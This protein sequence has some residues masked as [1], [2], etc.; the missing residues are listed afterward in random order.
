[1]N[2]KNIQCFH[3][4]YEERNLSQAA[5]KL[6]LSPQGLGKII[7][8][9]EDECQI[10]LFERTNAGWIPTDA[11][12][13]FYERSL[14]INED[15]NRMM[16]EIR[17]VRENNAKVKI[18]FASGILRIVDQK[19]MKDY[20]ENNKNIE[21]M[22]LECANDRIEK[23]IKQSMLNLGY[24]IGRPSDKE[25]FSKLVKMVP[26][27]MY[28]YRGHKFFERDSVSIEDFAGEPVVS[29]NDRFHIYSDFLEACKLKDFI[30]HIAAKVSEGDVFESLIKEGVGIGIAPAVI[31]EDYDMR[32]VKIEGGYTWDIYSVCRKE[33]ISLKVVDKINTFIGDGF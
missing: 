24:R 29:M 13:V 1:M 15:Y 3:V 16:E 27:K 30:P 22:W 14:K 17:L 28:V 8:K 4:L 2:T 23:M 5:K 31:K 26:V 25:L 7:T 20:I 21:N 12:E 6:F 9:L 32:A 10:R 18:G 11:G 33:N 19:S